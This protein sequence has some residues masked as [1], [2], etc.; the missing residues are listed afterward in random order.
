LNNEN[1]ALLQTGRRFLR[2][3]TGG[4]ADNLVAFVRWGDG[5]TPM[6]VVHNLWESD[7]TARFVVPPDLAAG[8]GMTACDEWRAVDTFTGA[9]LVPCMAGTEWTRSIPIRMPWNRRAAWAR[10]EMCT[11][12]P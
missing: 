1:A 5:E 12:L 9:V 11:D 7:S 6:L 8:I 2:T 3:H 10:I 4:Q